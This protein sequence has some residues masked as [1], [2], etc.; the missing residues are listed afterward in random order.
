MERHAG[1]P[2]GMLIGV[3]MGTLCGFANGA[4]IT[5]LRINPFI[6]TLGTMGIFRGSR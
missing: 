6:V 2:A 4:M 3:L 1:I 5:F